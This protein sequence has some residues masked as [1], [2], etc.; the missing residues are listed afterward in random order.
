MIIIGLILVEAGICAL[1]FFA[2]K[3]VGLSMALRLAETAQETD[4][5]IREEIVN[6]IKRALGK[7]VDDENA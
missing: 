6:R 2:G 4:A 3:K 5:Y 1:F 7:K